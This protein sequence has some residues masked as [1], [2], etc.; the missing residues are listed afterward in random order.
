MSKENPEIGEDN[1]WPDMPGPDDQ[2]NG[3]VIV[4]R[5]QLNALV[6]LNQEYRADI[7]TLVS[8]FQ[9]FSGLFDESF[10]I[11]KVITQVPKMM[12]D[13]QLRAKILTMSPVIEKYTTPNEITENAQEQQ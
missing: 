2:D 6:A 4:L 7:I 5:D 3:T 11:T 8:V 10:S 12:K 13:Q 9:H 1:N